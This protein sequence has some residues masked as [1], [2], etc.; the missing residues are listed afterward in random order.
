MLH[1]TS[2]PYAGNGFFIKTFCNKSIDVFEGSTAA[3]TPIIQWSYHGHNNQIWLV[4]PASQQQQ[5]QP[6]PQPYTQI[7]SKNTF[8]EVPASFTPANT[9]YKILSALN[10]TKAL[11]VGN[12]HTVRISDYTGDASQ[13][14]MIMQDGAKFAF[15]V[16]SF[17]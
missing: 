4:S 1:V 10:T 9:T 16:G 12:D 17:Q 14:F 13:R 2:G 3:G 11:T 5:Q 15:V 7:T 6:K 8:Q